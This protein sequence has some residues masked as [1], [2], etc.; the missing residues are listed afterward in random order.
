MSRYQ[1]LTKVSAH[2]NVYAHMLTKRVHILF[3]KDLWEKTTKMAKLKNTSIG[4]IIRSSVKERLEKEKDTDPKKSMINSIL[5]RRPG[6][7]KGRG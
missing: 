7:F 3:D 6:A 5:D 4:D 2:A 1:N